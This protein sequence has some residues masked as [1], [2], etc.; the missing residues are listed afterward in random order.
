MTSFV[1][2][3]TWLDHFGVTVSWRINDSIGGVNHE[4]IGG[5]PRTSPR[6]LKSV[7]Q[8][9]SSFAAAHET[10][11]LHCVG[12]LRIWVWRSF[13][14]KAI[15]VEFL[16][17]NCMQFPRSD[18]WVM[19]HF[20]FRCPTVLTS[21]RHTSRKCKRQRFAEEGSHREQKTVPIQL[22]TVP[23]FI[24]VCSWKSHCTANWGVLEPWEKHAEPY[25]GHKLILLRSD[26]KL[27]LSL[28][29]TNT[30][31]W[32]SMGERMYIDPHF[33]DLGTSWRWVVSCTSRPL[34]PRY[35]LDRLRGPQSQ[36]GRR[37]AKILDPTETRTRYTDYAI[38]APLRIDE[39]CKYC[40]M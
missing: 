35:L 25:L 27:K 3:V 33:L 2:Q 24:L 6:D 39:C 10:R 34:Y 32:R 40:S 30:T 12:R 23:N 29:L 14:S 1:M 7:M 31:P 17:R 13:P 28:C 4:A 36:S 15:G 19:T 20:I 8:T 37:E 38:P 9:R 21:S 16:T 18:C 22:Q 5:T 26:G 11:M